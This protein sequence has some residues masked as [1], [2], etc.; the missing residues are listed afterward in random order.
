MEENWTDEWKAGYTYVKH[1]L[2]E[3]NLNHQH[4]NRVNLSKMY[5]SHWMPFYM[6]NLLIA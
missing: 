6:Y 5:I 3:V 4:V 1:K 2:K